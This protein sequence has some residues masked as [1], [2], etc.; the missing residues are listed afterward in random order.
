MAVLEKIEG[1]NG[2]RRKNMD[3]H[4]RL[5]LEFARLKQAYEDLKKLVSQVKTLSVEVL[6]EAGTVEVNVGLEV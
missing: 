1:E 3:E 6:T 5:A 2:R 4:A